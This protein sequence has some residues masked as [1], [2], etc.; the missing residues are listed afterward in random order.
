MVGG[1][2]GGAGV[3]VGVVVRWRRGVCVERVMVGDHQATI[4]GNGTGSWVAK[5]DWIVMAY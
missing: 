3:G 4:M 1:G 2:A 5:G